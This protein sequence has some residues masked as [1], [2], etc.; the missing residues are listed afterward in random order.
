[1]THVRP[2]SQAVED[3]MLIT[4]GEVDWAYGHALTCSNISEGVRTDWPVYFVQIRN[5]FFLK[6][7][8]S[9]AD[10]VFISGYY[11]LGNILCHSRF[12]DHTHNI[13]L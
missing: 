4:R 8:H 10:K 12:K 7:H 11:E 5:Y 6:F 9:S 13:I 2:S 3:Q 1:M